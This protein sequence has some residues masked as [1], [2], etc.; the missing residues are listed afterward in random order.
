MKSFILNLLKGF[1]LGLSMVLPGI[2]GGT[3]AFIMGIYE[4]LIEEISALKKTHIKEALMC[5]SFN[6]EKIRSYL[7]TLKEIWDWSFLLPLL[8]G[9]G[10]SIV[11]FILFAGDWIQTYSFIFYSFVLGLILASL[12]SPFQQM[13]KNLQTFLFFILSLSFNLVLFTTETESFNIQTNIQN[14]PLLFVPIGFFVSIT[15]II[16][17]ISGAYLLLVLGLYEKTISALKNLDAL[18]ITLFLL[19]VFFGFILTAKLIKKILTR[20]WDNS[21]AIILGLIL[22]SVYSIYPLKGEEIVWNK[23]Y[24]AFLTWASLGFLLFFLF[25]LY[26]QRKQSVRKRAY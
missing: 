2:S 23:R 6:K 1:L 8:I 7:F 13:Q 22:G 5:L 9:M 25:H 3:L 20:H 18:I 14:N 12:I 17:G 26:L 21:L 10:L 19:G 11:L 4:K 15:L 16:P 24:S